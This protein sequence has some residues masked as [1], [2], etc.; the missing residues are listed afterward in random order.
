MEKIEFS[1]G[2]AAF[3]S[4]YDGVSHEQWNSTE[5]FIVNLRKT[6][7]SHYLSQQKYRCAY[8]RMEK[9]EQHGLTWD[10]EHIIPK[11]THPKFL[12]EPENLAM[13]CKE[14]NIAKANKDVLV[15]PLSHSS[16]YPTKSEDYKIVHP[17][18]DSYSENFELIVVEGRVTH[19]PK[20]SHKAKE[21][22]LM[23]DLIRFSYAFA[24]WEDFN[25]AIVSKFSHFVEN[26]PKEAT[27][28]QIASFMRTLTF[29]IQADF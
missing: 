12:Y 6:I 18:Y 26:C 13:A 29:T 20:N 5:G 14:C 7:R 15:K 10:V 25:H 21:T 11:A 8:C 16:S 4:R 24:E 3:I 1:G 19:R 2:D 23:C 9:K 17:H 27:K 28:E 22:F